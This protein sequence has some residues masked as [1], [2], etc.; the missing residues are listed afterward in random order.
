MAWAD[1]SQRAQAMP[2]VRTGRN[3]VV[4]NRLAVSTPATAACRCR[5]QSL[6]EGGMIYDH[7]SVRSDMQYWLAFSWPYN[8]LSD[9][10]IRITVYSCANAPAGP[11]RGSRA[12]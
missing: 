8:L 6:T 12:G 11:E 4:S 10:V 1:A 9:K 2:V 5:H 7:V 3:F